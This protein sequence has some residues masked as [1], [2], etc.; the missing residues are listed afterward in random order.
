MMLT[1][2]STAR[3]AAITLVGV[4]VL[5]GCASD[6]KDP[7]AGWSPNKIYS[8]ARDEAAS[9]AFEKAVTLFEKL[10]GRA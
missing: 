6:P 2:L 1:G 7:T 5:T 9:G 10:E 4:A 3:L 8:E